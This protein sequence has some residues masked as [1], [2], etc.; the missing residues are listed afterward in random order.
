MAD[1]YAFSR[2]FVNFGMAMA[3]RIPMITTTTRSSIRVKPRRDVTAY[4]PGAKGRRTA[5]STASRPVR[6]PIIGHRRPILQEACLPLGIDPIPAHAGT[7]DQRNAQPAGGF[8]MAF[9]K[10]ARDRLLRFRDL[11]HQLV[12]DLEHHPSAEVSLAERPVDANHR[13][14]DEVGGGALERGIG[15]RALAEGADVEVAVAQLRNVAAAPEDRLDEALLAGGGD[16]AIQPRPHAGEA[17]EVLP[18]EFL[19]FLLRDAQLAG[20]GERALAVDRAE[21]DRLGACAHLGGDLV[22]RHAED[23][24]RGL[25]VDV[26]PLLERLHERGIA[27]QVRE[28]SQLDLGRSEERR[29]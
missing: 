9:Y 10:L 12:M 15:R 18:D 29:V 22:L 5:S 7:Y 25:A 3:A 23:D 1:T 4:P 16:R 28:Q 19:R 8:H 24:R 26:A 20:E 21:I 11:E 14:L 17:R 27:G 6:R 2:V 13:D